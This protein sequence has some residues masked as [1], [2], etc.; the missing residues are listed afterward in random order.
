MG[1]SSEWRG[2]RKGSENFKTEQQ[3]SPNLNNR[4][5]I[6]RKN[7]RASET[8]GMV[9]KD[10]TSV[11]SESKN[12]PG[13]SDSTVSAC[14]VGDLGSIPE[15]ERSS[16]EGNGN[17]LQY[18]CLENPMDGGAWYATVGLQKVGHV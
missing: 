8:Y 7:S 1:S 16:G 3:K 9:T 18:L 13:G 17:P 14:N 10:L 5:K 2:Q 11:L 4:E 6:D 15:S 12:F